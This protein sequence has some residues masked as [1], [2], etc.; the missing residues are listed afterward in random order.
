MAGKRKKPSLIRRWKNGWI[1]TDRTA[2]RWRFNAWFD[3]LILDHGLIRLF[4]TNSEHIADGVWR[5]NQPDPFRIAR[6]KKRGIKA[7]LNLRG[8]TLHS[9][10]LLEREA[11]AELGLDLIDVKM[12]SRNLPDLRSIKK[13]DAIFETI[14]RPFA[15]HCKSG[16]DRAGF[17]SAL[18]LLL[19]TDA[20]V[21]E[22]KKQLSWKYMHF[23]RSSTG[24][25]DFVLDTYAADTAEDPIS[26]RDW[27][28]TK[29]NPARLHAAFKSHR[30]ADALVDKVLMRE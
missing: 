11:C 26:F 20:P 13:L 15:F 28:E 24:I 19:R 10:Y 7:I 16:A 25:L 9:A 30:A 8:E 4:W 23:K 29:Y 5:M 22:A 1:Y 6:M 17:I 14:A 12:E 3:M 21:G 18:Y 2:F 27:L